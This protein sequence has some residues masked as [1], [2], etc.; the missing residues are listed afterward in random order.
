LTLPVNI[1]SYS[2]VLT[3]NLGALRKRLGAG[4]LDYI[5]LLG[6]LYALK[7]LGPQQESGE[8][9]DQV[10]FVKRILWELYCANDEIKHHLDANLAKFNGTKGQP[11]T[12][13]LLDRLL[14]RQWYRLSFW[15]VAAEEL[16]YRRF[17]T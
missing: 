13:N 15:K 16:N 10:E 9:I 8:R 17:S 6:V 12:F 3:D 5:K 2:D 1:E 4:H 11:E 14:L 7:N